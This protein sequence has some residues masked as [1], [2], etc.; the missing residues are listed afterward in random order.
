VLAVGNGTSTV[1]SLPNGRTVLYDAGCFPPYDL[2][3]WTIGPLLSR[4]RCWRIDAAIVSHANLDHY[5]GLPELLDRRWVAR[6]I[7][8]P[9]FAHA[10]E[11]H[12]TSRE[13]MARLR[14][15]PGLWQTVSRGNR[16]SGTGESQLEVLWP[17]A[18]EIGPGDT[19]DTSLVLRSSYAG[20]RILACG[21][22]EEYAMQRLLATAD[23]RADVLLLPHH[24]SV[25]PSTAEFIRAVDPQYCIRCTGRRETSPALLE[26]I[27]GRA[28]FSTATD[29]A[30]NV[31]IDRGEIAVA[32]AC[33]KR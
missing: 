26:A 4:E 7:T 2:E 1:I 21:D 17:P 25:T 27:D 23:L 20:K 13:L 15:K 10:G 31:R 14:V 8:T 18:E 5:A 19:N 32:P 3:R 11:A 22:I 24:G 28:Y 12:S 29:G 33:G 30:I 6:V 9:H 16:L